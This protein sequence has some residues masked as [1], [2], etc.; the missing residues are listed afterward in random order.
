[1]IREKVAWFLRNLWAVKNIIIV[2][3]AFIAPINLAIGDSKETK[4][5][6]GLIVMATL[7]LT[8]ALPIPV[9]ALL[10]TVIFPLLGVSTARTICSKY[11]N[12]TT[13]LFLGGL[14]VA[15]AVEE[16]GLHTRIAMGI[17]SVLGSNPNMLMLGLMLPTWFLSMWISN[18]A[19]TSMMIPIIQAVMTQIK[20]ANKIRLEGAKERKLLLEDVSESENPT[21]QTRDSI[22]VNPSEGKIKNGAM[23]TVPT[24]TQ[25]SPANDSAAWNSILSML[26]DEKSTENSELRLFGKGLALGVAYGANAGG[27]ATLTGTP[28]NLILQGQAN[29][30]FDKRSP[31]SDSGIT[32]ANWMGFAFPLSI[33]ILLLSWIWLQLFFLR[34]L[35]IR[36]TDAVRTAAIQSAIR[37]ERKKIGRVTFGEIVVLICFI[38][39]AMLWIFRDIPGLGGWAYLFHLDKDGKPFAR[40]ST[41]AMLIAIVLFVLPKSV[42]NIFCFIKSNDEKPSYS[43]ILTWDKVVHKLPWGVIVLLGGGFALANASSSSGLS[44]MVGCSLRVFSHMDIWVMNLIICLIVAGATEITS[45]SATATLLMPIMAEL[46]LSLGKNP[47]YLMISSAVACSFAF[48]LPVAT[49]PNAI[50]FSTG[51]LRIPDMASA[52][53]M[54]NVVAILALTLAVNTWAIPIFSLD[55][56]PSIFNNTDVNS[57]CL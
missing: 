6:Y 27:I 12:D 2:F 31:G 46:A 56:I 32:F 9:T 44:K 57:T 45:N 1:M 55:V 16:V 21:I 22:S 20:E 34:S 7:W 50:V 51:I 11:I 30:I 48:M 4:C 3:I 39:L 29:E 42:P 15:V 37:H 10:P 33:V 53:I 26:E 25:I 47:L 23:L 38:C 18:T 52:G 41:A 54:M 35:C 43:P 24:D 5:A 8:E 13:V 28:P 49:P 14:V 17:I 36:K 19:A 40:D